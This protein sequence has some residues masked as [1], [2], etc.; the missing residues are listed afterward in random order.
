MQ[1]EKLIELLD[2]NCGYTAEMKADDLADYLID[3]G[4]TVQEWISMKERQP[5][6]TGAYIATQAGKYVFIGWYSAA[7]DNWKVLTQSKPQKCRYPVTHWMPLPERPKE[8]ER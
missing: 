6:R 2:M 1:K 5:E 3:N 8:G 4:V 7:L